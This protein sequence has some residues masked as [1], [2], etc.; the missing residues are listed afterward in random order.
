[1]RTNS[2]T[3][4]HVSF[5][6]FF[7]DPVSRLHKSSYL[8]PFDTQGNEYISKSYSDGTRSYQYRNRQVFPSLLRHITRRLLMV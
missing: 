7:Q 5:P 4:S 1:M 6:L 8:P 2:G 3:N